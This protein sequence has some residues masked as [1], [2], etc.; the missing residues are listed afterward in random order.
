MGD[1]PKIKTTLKK[2]CPYC[3]SKNIGEGTPTGPGAST[4]PPGVRTKKPSRRRH[5]C[6]KCK[7]QFVR[8][9]K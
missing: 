1:S 2:E 3:G 5:I 6:P 7:Q 8:I 4:Q 9:L